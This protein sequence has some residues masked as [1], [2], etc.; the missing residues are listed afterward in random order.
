MGGQDRWQNN[1][2]GHQEEVRSRTLSL[3]LLSA[4]LKSTTLFFLTFVPNS[5]GD[6]GAQCVQ[7]PFLSSD[8]TGL[9][10]G[11]LDDRRTGC[12][13]CCDRPTF[14]FALHG[15]GRHLLPV[16]DLKGT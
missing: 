6:L 4:Q 14:Q 1:K 12:Q 11:E 15:K 5:S 7:G 2:G 8:D 3:S 13:S 10:G 16:H 9:G